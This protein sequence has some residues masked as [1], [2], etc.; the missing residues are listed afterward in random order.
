MAIVA[1]TFQTY[2]AIGQREDLSDIIYN[3]SPTETPF[4]SAIGKTKATAIN[5]EWQTD[6][7]KDAASNAQL[8]GDEVTFPSG[9][10]TV[11]V[12]L[13]NRAQISSKPVIVSGTLDAVSEAGRNSEMA[14]QISK[15][16]KELK[17]DMEF[18]LCG[19]NQAQTAGNNTTARKLA[20]VDS[21]IRTNT[22]IGGG[23]G[24][25][26]N[27]T[28][29]NAR[30]DGTQRAF[31][32][33]ML[34]S[35]SASCWNNGGEPSMIMVGS[36]NKQKISEFTGGSTKFTQSEEKKLV[37]SIDVYES[38]FGTM[39]VVPNRFSR[40]R[41]AYIMQPD[42]WAVAFLRDFTFSEL[43]KTGDASK[44]FLLAEYTLEARNEAANGIVADLTTA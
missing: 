17:R 11:T 40:S 36:F 44:N 19:V 3:I 1:N 5:H 7:L 16:S 15:A 12:R 34:K 22:S 18:N 28:G 8:E 39:Q 25:N 37:A 23:S 4:I 26:P 20:P 43:A 27:A 9:W 6:A 14:Y 30:T 21:W 41:Q 2:T 31:T 10:N 38:D 24:A 13:G 35:V 29:T 33:D 32:E 42:M